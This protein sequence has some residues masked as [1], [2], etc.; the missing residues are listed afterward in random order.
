M[1]CYAHLA[2]DPV[3]ATAATVTSEIVASMQGARRPAGKD[4]PRWYLCTSA[5]A[6]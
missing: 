3:N 5:P 2:G 6:G 1:A 4:G